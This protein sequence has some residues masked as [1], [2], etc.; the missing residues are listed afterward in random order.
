MSQIGGSWLGF[1]KGD[2]K[3][4]P[5]VFWGLLGIWYLQPNLFI[6]LQHEFCGSDWVFTT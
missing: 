5:M 4:K 1:L 3:R 6:S 2:N